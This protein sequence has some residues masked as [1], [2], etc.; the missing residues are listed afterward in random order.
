[1]LVLAGGDAFH[2]LPRIAVIRTGREK[3]LR[4]ALGTGK[5]V[6][7]VTMTVFYLLLWRIGVL[8]FSPDGISARSLAVYALA[9]VR[10]ILCLLPHNK[11]QKRYPPLSWAIARNIPF[12]LQ[13][14]LV[15]GLFCIHRSAVPGLASMWLAVA[16]SF[17]FYLPVVLWSNKKPKIGILMLPKTCAYLWML[18][19]CLSL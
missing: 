16:L 18:A 13:G 3:E 11:W 15:A 7:S 5:Q 1:V 14:T 2:L 6:A 9:A 4:K 17:A 12:F 10:M 8:V 19:M